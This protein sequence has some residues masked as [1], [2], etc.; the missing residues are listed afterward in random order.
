MNY[1]E[2]LIKEDAMKKL[3]VML[4]LIMFCGV[5]FAG[6]NQTTY[7]NLK[8]PATQDPS[9]DVNTL[10]DYEEGTWT[11]VPASSAGTITTVGTVSGTYTKVGRVII[12]MFNIAI[13]DNGTG[14]GC[15]KVAGITPFVPA[16][17]S[18][19]FG[20]NGSTGKSLSVSIG[21][22]SEFV[23]TNYDGTYPVA[24]G[25]TIRCTVIYKE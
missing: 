3:L 1:H 16:A 23:I 6:P 18:I 13:T 7:G 15:L 2:V 9:T 25:Q 11:P 17:S 19:G 14:S 21:N 10:D 5:A 8:F 22:P 20:Y 24:S 12:A 4:M